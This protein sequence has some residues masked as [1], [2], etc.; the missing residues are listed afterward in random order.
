MRKWL[1]AIVALFVVFSSGCASQ[2]KAAGS[3]PESDML[4]EIEPYDDAPFDALPD[5]VAAE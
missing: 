5:V 1:F 3:A 2:Q 4:A